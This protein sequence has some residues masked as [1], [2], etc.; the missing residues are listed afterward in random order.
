MELGTKE[1][2]DDSAMFGVWPSLVGLAF[3]ASIVGLMFAL[4]TGF[5]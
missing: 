1:A 5:R 4:A 3:G 2:R